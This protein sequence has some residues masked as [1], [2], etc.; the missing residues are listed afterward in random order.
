MNFITPNVR[1]NKSKYITYKILFSYYL[2]GREVGL[3]TRDGYDDFQSIQSTSASAVC[4]HNICTKIAL[5]L[6][7]S[8]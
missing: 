8:K 3:V 5:C 6:E 1:E 4:M 7:I 2:V